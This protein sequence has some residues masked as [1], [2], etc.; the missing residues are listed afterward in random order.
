MMMGNFDAGLYV[1]YIECNDE[2]KDQIMTGLQ[3]HNSYKIFFLVSGNRKYSI[4][5]NACVMKPGDIILINKMDLYKPAVV[6]GCSFERI[7]ISFNDDFLK[8][9]DI[10][11]NI[12]ADCFKLNYVKL[13]AKDSKYISQLFTKILI[14]YNNSQKYSEILVQHYIYELLIIIYRYAN[15]ENIAISNDAETDT[16]NRAM[17]YIYTNYKRKLTL[18]EISKICHVNP[19]Y[20]SRL[21]KKNVGMTFV[22]Y[23]NTIRMKEAVS[24]LKNTDMS[25]GEISQEC[26]FDNLQYF[27]EMFKKAKGLSPQQYRKSKINE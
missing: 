11:F 22:K 16:I 6:E 3:Y 8:K 27:C 26:G 10:D 13:P 19:S 4:N 24:L 21:F 23:L 18:S 1:D 25:I 17:R 7:L 15:S 5:C 14:E 2:N 9:L 12:V 20:F